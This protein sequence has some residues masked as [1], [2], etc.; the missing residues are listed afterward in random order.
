M[1]EE[2]AQRRLAAILAAD[3]VGYTRL[4]ER[5]EAGTLAAVKSRR[6]EV[7]QPLVFKHQGR[8][9]KLMGDGV[10]VEF[11]SA[12]NAVA[13]AVELQEAMGVANRGV[14]QDRQIAL[15]VGINLGDVIVEGSDLYGDG[16]NVAARL[17][18][19]APPG[20]VVISAK[21]QQEVANKLALSFED[22]GARSLKNIAEPVRLYR[23]SA[24]A[25][26]SEPPRMSDA[27]TAS[28]P[29]IAVL[30]FAN[31]SGDPE[32]EYFSDGITE[33][34]I[35]EL[36]RFRSLF[37][38]AHNSSFAY[39]GRTLDLREI[40][41]NL[42]VRYIVEGSIRRA[43]NHVRVT[44]QLIDAGTGNHLWAERF[45]RELK[46]IFSVQD[47][48]AR[49]IVT[50]VAPR[51]EAEGIDL[52]RRKPPQDMRA[53]DYFLR[54]KLL[55]EAP[56]AGADLNQA[57]EYCDRA[58]EIDPSY[59]RAH[60]QK[61]FT[62]VIG[63]LLMEPEN[64]EE[65][66]RR[67][68]QCAE[69]AVSLDPMDEFC[70]WSLGEAAVQAKQHDRA[71]DHMARALA[72]NPNDANILAGSGYIYAIT[73]NPEAGLRQ[74]GTALERNPSSPSW[75]HWLRG[76]IL[77][78]LGRFDEALRAFNLH[79]PPNPSI[80]R[81]RAA[82]LVE[83][84]RFDEARADIRSILAIRPGATI[85]EARRFLDYAPD[86]DHYLDSLRKAGLPE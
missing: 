11:A 5:D 84:G 38:I 3:V 59:A 13:C 77:Y 83:L 42:G 81:W 12:L 32:Q 47:D 70:H 63:I 17:E 60:A 58:I 40:G 72:I 64:V 6:A 67:A 23:V 66:R 26:S 79:S 36:S 7:L 37:V 34:I 45:D 61:A 30:P 41:R 24:A 15:R 14:S 31:M 8:I 62:Y 50:S 80:L 52:A 69:S 33:D 74:M 2:R 35:T 46:D 18:A 28:K 1:P 71:L 85:S 4:M 51:I 49:R 86:P 27:T 75:Y 20:G 65:W 29:S 44:A 55:L 82:T 76:T 16:V 25:A 9:V 78:V 48:I 43:G 22:L 56:H 21:V 10:L 19:L 54:A 57:R 39:K 68:L 73:G 53:Y